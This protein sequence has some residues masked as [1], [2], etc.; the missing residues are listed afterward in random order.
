MAPVLSTKSEYVK[1]E[2]AE[3]IDLEKLIASNNNIIFIGKRE[4]GKT[5]ILQK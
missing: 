4:S 3:E 1:E 5:T 2:M